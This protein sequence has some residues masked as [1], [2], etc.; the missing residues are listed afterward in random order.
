VRIDR[1]APAVSCGSAD[2]LWHA[3]DVSIACTATDALSGLAN[4]ADAAFLLATSVPI[5]TE[6]NNACTGVRT[7]QDRANNST[8]AGPVCGNKVDKRAPAISITTPPSG[9]VYLLN[10]AV[11]AVYSCADGGSGV[12]TCAGPVAAGAPIDT[13]AVGTKTFTVMASDNVGNARS[14]SVTYVVTYNI[15]LLYNPDQPFSGSVVPI[16]IALCD[17]N[18]VN[19]SSPGVIVHATVVDPGSIPATSIVNPTNDFIYYAGLG[20]YTYILN[21]TGYAHGNYQLRFTVTGDPITHSA[22]FRLR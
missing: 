1:V 10:Q 17:V 21:V 19:V 4:S 6:T 13:S 2:G 3:S 14:L 22:P 15:C 8:T 20:G 18:N 7:V 16:R 11:L 12:A 9:A 5:E